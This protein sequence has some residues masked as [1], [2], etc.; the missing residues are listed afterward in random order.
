MCVRPFDERSDGTDETAT[1]QA[2]AKLTQ[3]GLT[4]K[5]RE[6]S[7]CAAASDLESLNPGA[8]QQ[9]HWIAEVEAAAASIEAAG[10]EAWDKDVYVIGGS[11]GSNDQCH[12]YSD[13]KQFLMHAQVHA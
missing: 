11:F 7:S 12:G 4:Y 5:F 10:G 8:P 3:E 1:W 13:G 2:D 9:L 6:V